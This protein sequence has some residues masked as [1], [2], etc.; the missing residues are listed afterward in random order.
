MVRKM[1]EFDIIQRTKDGYFNATHLFNQWNKKYPNEQR[2]IDNFWK[3][4]NLEDLMR[5]IV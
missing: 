3:S 5:E 2:Q 1:G 4:T